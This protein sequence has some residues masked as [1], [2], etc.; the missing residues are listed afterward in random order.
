[1]PV[2]PES[3]AI[4]SGRDHA[5]RRWTP[6]LMFVAGGVAIYVVQTVAWITVSVLLDFPEGTNSTVPF[7]ALWLVLVAFPLVA[8]WLGARGLRRWFA[9]GATTTM[10]LLLVEVAVTAG[11][12]MNDPEAAHRLEVTAAKSPVVL[13]YPGPRFYGWR[14]DDEGIDHGDD[15]GLDTADTSLDPGDS[16]F[17]G[18]GTT[19]T[20]NTS[21]TCGVRYEIDLRTLRATDVADRCVH[22]LP[23][24]RGVT[25][26]E[27]EGQGVV[28]FVDRLVV[29]FADQPK[30]TLVTDTVR[31]L[32]PVGDSSVSADDLPA[33]P[34]SVAQLIGRCPVRPRG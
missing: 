3:T 27:L 25:P 22:R 19:C 11:R 24:T 5:G 23:T 7:I 14:L 21:G 8:V 6:P 33:P 16:L 32:R 13:Y 29:A 30:D 34:A 31:A 17:L 2:K 18:Y 28:I 20:T 12:P 26:V 10:L 9:I 1:V 4:G 15:E